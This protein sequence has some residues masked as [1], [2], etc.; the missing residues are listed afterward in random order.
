MP[1]TKHKTDGYKLI[2]YCSYKSLSSE[3][4]PQFSVRTVWNTTGKEKF[5][6]FL[7]LK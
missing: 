1:T 5:R 3:F 6:N 7:H 2:Q 4:I